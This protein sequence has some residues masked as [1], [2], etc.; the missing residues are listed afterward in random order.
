LLKGDYT[1]AV[2]LF[3]TGN[4]NLR[5]PYC[6][7]KK[8]GALYPIHMATMGGNLKLVRWLTSERFCPL[9]TINLKKKVN[10]H[11]AYDPIVTSKG[12]TALEIALI[13][14]R[15]DIVHF[16][17]SEMKLSISDQKN[18][19]TDIVLANLTSLLNMLPSNFFEATRV[20]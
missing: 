19:S 8:A 20:V 10:N 7:D 1:M 5:T 2:D 17:V 18:V 16:F 11:F 4:V 15:I 3:K 6:L 12:L 9:Q 13:N 14:R